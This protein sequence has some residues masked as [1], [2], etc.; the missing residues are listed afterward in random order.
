MSPGQPTFELGCRRMM[1]LKAE[2]PLIQNVFYGGPGVL[3]LPE[4]SVGGYGDGIISGSVCFLCNLPRFKS[5]R[6]ADFNIHFSK[7]FTTTIVPEI[8]DSCFGG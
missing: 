4:S 2:P 6:E 8:A 5:R 3:K 7:H 1:T